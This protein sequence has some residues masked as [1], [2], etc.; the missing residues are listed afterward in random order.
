VVEQGRAR[1]LALGLLRPISLYP[2][3]VER[4]R[5]LSRTARK[6]LVVELSTGQMVDDVRLAVDGRCPVEFYG[7]V[8][9]NV[10]SA[11][12]VLA[13]LGL[14]TSHQ[15]LVT[16]HGTEEVQVYA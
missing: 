14:P 16:S 13:E 7:R 12:E 4:L 10:P 6:F 8:G 1:G 5:E 2:F 15:P 3:P 9:G 11:E